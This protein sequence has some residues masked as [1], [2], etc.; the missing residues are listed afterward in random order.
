MIA[1][2]TQ[3]ISAPRDFSTVSARL[4]SAVDLHAGVFRVVLQGVHYGQ[5][6]VLNWFA[7]DH[8]ILVC[9]EIAGYIGAERGQ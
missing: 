4:E 9:T 2:A 5:Y 1:P 3:V 8:L 7:A 6:S